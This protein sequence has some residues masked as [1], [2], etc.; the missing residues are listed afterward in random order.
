MHN[1]RFTFLCTEE[2]KLSIERLAVLYHRSKGDTIRLLVR[3]AI[4]QSKKLLTK[5]PQPGKDR[6][7]TKESSNGK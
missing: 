3:Q 4:E 1:I 6:L 7:K 2:E 5:P